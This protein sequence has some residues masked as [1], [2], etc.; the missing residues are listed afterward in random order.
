MS[1]LRDVEF[2]PFR[3]AIEAG[4]ASV[5]S[6]HVLVREL[7]DARPATLSPDVVEALLRKELKF[8]RVVFTDDMDMKAVAKRWPPAQAAVLAAKAG[9]DVIS[10]C[11]NHEAQVA[12]IA[13]ASQ[14]RR[15][16]DPSGSPL[17]AAT[18]WSLR[19]AADHPPLT[20]R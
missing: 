17:A 19:R 9:C 16:T 3:A 13:K 15:M 14:G 18:G 5:M 7:D 12:A 8:D 2:R 1:R 6:C 10:M 4:V 11:A 20:S